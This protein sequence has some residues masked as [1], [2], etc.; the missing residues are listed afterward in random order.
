MLTVLRR[1]AV[2]TLWVASRSPLGDQFGPTIKTVEQLRTSV[3][4]TIA[5]L[6]E[7]VNHVDESPGQL[8][9]RHR[10]VVELELDSLRNL[11]REL[12]QGSLSRRSW[13]LGQASIP[14]L[15][16]MLNAIKRSKIELPDGLLDRARGSVAELAGALER[17]AEGRE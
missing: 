2:N 16:S 8:K 12:S 13:S 4:Q 11:D 17:Q 1:L 5:D 9:H 14:I 15:S 6:C 3:S 10:K 7:L